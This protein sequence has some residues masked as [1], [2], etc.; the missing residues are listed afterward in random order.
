LYKHC[1]CCSLT[2]YLVLVQSRT[3]RNKAVHRRRAS[4]RFGLNADKV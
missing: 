3:S 2:A 4:E 1:C